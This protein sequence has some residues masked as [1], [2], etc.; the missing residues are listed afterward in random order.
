MNNTV[1]EV[2][3]L[4]KEIELRY[5]AEEKAIGNFTIAVNRDY[6]NKDGIYETDFFNCVVYGKIVETIKE[7]TQKGDLIG[8]RG[9]LQNRSYE[10]ETGKHYI[11]EIIVEKVSFLSAKKKEDN[12]YKDMSVKTEQQQQFEITDADL[13]F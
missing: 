1:M 6:K 12:P 5:T 3:R 13:P 10:N 8:L 11:T 7:Y 2:G 9:K 4:V